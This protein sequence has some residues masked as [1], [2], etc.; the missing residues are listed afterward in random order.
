MIRTAA[1]EALSQ[2]T[3]AA[4]CEA[5]LSRTLDIGDDYRELHEAHP[6]FL[7]HVSL[8]KWN[9]PIEIRSKKALPL[10][11]QGD[12]SDRPHQNANLR[13]SDCLSR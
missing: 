10:W 5:K 6:A 2:M 12:P 11:L 4:P 7:P 9:A 13:G 3:D 1:V 8:S